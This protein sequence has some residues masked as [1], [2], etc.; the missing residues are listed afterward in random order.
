MPFEPPDPT[1]EY[2]HSYEGHEKRLV[3][4]VVAYRGLRARACDP[5][6]CPRLPPSRRAAQRRTGPAVR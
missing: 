6:A 4:F 2:S 1:C 5:S 3:S